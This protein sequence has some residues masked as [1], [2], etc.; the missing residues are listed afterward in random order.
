MQLRGRSHC[1]WIECN[2]HV[3]EIGENLFD[4]LAEYQKLLK[5]QSIDDKVLLWVD[6][7]CINQKD[8][9]ERSAQVS[10]MDQIYEAATNVI[11]WLGQKDLASHAAFS[12]I[13]GFGNALLA[14]DY[15][16]E[17]PRAIEFNDANFFT[18]IGK[19]QPSM[20][21]WLLIQE[22][23]MRS[24]FR[25][26]WTVQ[27]TTNASGPDGTILMLCG[28]QVFQWEDFFIFTS[29]VMTQGWFIALNSARRLKGPQSYGIRSFSIMV[30]AASESGWDDRHSTHGDTSL[31]YRLFMPHDEASFVAA[32]FA[33]LMHLGRQ[34]E[35][36]D[37]R[38][39][40]FAPLKMIKQYRHLSSTFLDGFVVDYSMSVWE[41][42]AMVTRFLILN[43]QNLSVLGIRESKT[44]RVV[45]GVEG[46][47]SWALDF[48]LEVALSPLLVG[49]DYGQASPWQGK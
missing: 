23:F 12:V 40:V 37:P 29:F 42:F 45:S 6:A 16:F 49:H 32:R 35:A 31:I 2:H 3:V 33:F 4:A 13:H 41:V 22:L 24:W 47:P 38:D 17:S 39:K 11:V 36:S 34:R 20:Q 46:L 27:E 8:R 7:L 30:D 15:R 26:I 48:T 5:S 9:A 10:I 25:R 1:L 21:Q 14:T 43:L 19:P 44:Q 28:D 18:S